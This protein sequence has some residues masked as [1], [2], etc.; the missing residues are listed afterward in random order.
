VKQSVRRNCTIEG[1]KQ[2]PPSSPLIQEGG[3]DG[4]NS[5]RKKIL[6]DTVIN[7][8]EKG[9]RCLK[10]KGTTASARGPTTSPS[11]V[12]KENQTHWGKT[13]LL[14]DSK[15]RFAA[16]NSKKKKLTNYT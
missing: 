14:K 8:R 15:K 11:R 2:F 3:N 12:Y 5:R 4:G 10:K 13:P 9:I 16:Q 7:L 1:G 6:A